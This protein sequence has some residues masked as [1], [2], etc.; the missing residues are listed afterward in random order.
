M[1]VTIQEMERNKIVFLFHKNNS[2]VLTAKK[3][4]YKSYIYKDRD[5]N[6][7]GRSNTKMNDE[8]IRKEIDD[9]IEEELNLLVDKFDYNISTIQM[10]VI[11]IEYFFSTNELLFATNALAG[12]DIIFERLK[13]RKP[14][15]KKKASINDFVAML[16]FAQEYY[17]LRDYIYY[18][19]ANKESISWKKKGKISIKV[20]DNSIF[21]QHM[22]EWN[23][24]FIN[25]LKKRD[26]TL[27][28]VEELFS[29]L[30]GQDEEEIYKNQEVKIFIENETKNKL[31]SYKFGMPKDNNISFGKYTLGEF[32]DI[33]ECLLVSAVY[34][35][36]YSFA[37][38]LPSVVITT[39]DEYIQNIN[40]YDEEKVSAILI[41]IARA[42]KGTFYYIE[43]DD[44]FVL[45]MSAFSLRNGINDLLRYHARINGNLLLTNI[46]GPLGDELVKEMENLFLQYENFKCKTDMKLN[47]FDESLPDIDLLIVSYEPSL[48]FHIYICE[49]KNALQAD[50][51]KEYLKGIDRN[52]YLTKATSQIEK[53]RNFLDTEE[54]IRYII[55][56]V[57][58]MFSDL[59][60]KH[61]FPDGLFFPIEFMIITSQNLGV[62]MEEKESIIIAAPVL[63]QFVDNSDGDVVYIEKCMQEYK[64]SIKN[65]YVTKMKTRYFKDQR[66][67]FE[68]PSINS[69]FTTYPNKY[70]SNGIYKKIE[71]ESLESGY[72]YSNEVKTKMEN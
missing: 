22:Q 2:T 32:L 33:Y 40:E 48:G 47:K 3:G 24:F 65:C 44:T 39:R 42:S 7:L 27:L 57:L 25:S 28:S 14:K 64:T 43:E 35:R 6:I 29:L 59:D 60:I 72:C 58:E 67:D 55:D 21:S 1:V 71:K 50:W 36:Y 70:I 61:L 4:F 68:V 69:I 26:V 46:S 31:D 12:L 15:P 8:E 34:R 41:D 51:A 17:V 38:D 20:N 11:I 49:I 13:T 63:K 23:L 54:G 9:I 53:I 52:G 56:N 62:V 10:F 19:F 5:N 37:N 30:K 66:V 18:S 16:D 45:S